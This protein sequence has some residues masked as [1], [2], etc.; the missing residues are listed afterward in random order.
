MCERKSSTI[1]QFRKQTH[2]FLKREARFTLKQLGKPWPNGTVKVCRNRSCESGHQLSIYL[3]GLI[4]F[5]NSLNSTSSS[6]FLFMV[7]YV[8]KESRSWWRGKTPAVIRL[9]PSTVRTYIEK[10]SARN[11]HTDKNERGHD[12]KEWRD[13]LNY[14][15]LQKVVEKGKVGGSS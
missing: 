6:L 10:T 8:G 12:G 9:F 7:G 3:M 5:S 11:T 14:M 2:M 1:T 4:S 15:T 13:E